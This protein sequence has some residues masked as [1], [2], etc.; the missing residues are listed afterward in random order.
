M[1][2]PHW[3]SMFDDPRKY[4]DS[5][6]VS[7]SCLST[8]QE[9]RC[10]EWVQDV[11]RISKESLM[12]RPL[13]DI[14]KQS[15]IISRHRNLSPV[16]SFDN[17]CY[18]DN[19]KEIHR[20]KTVEDTNKR[21]RSKRHNNDTSL[22]RDTK[23]DMRET[24][25]T[26]TLSVKNSSKKHKYRDEYVG[27]NNANHSEVS[28]VL[29]HKP[30]LGDS[31][32]RKESE[33]SGTEL[34]RDLS[35]KKRRR[36][37]CI[38]PMLIM[39][40]LIIGGLFTAIAVVFLRPLEEEAE[41]DESGYKMVVASV[42]L[43][44]LNQT[45]NKDMRNRN[46]K[47]YAEIEEP[48]CHEMDG[49][50][51]F[52]EYSGNYYGCKVKM[53][54]SGSIRVLEELIFRETHELRKPTS[55]QDLIKMSSPSFDWKGVRVINVGDFVVDYESIKVQVDLQK[56]PEL[57]TKPLL[58]VAN[59]FSGVS[60]STTPISLSTKRIL[61]RPKLWKWGK[62]TVATTTSR[63]SAAKPTTMTSAVVP[64]HRDNPTTKA[65]N[66]SG[67]K[68]TKQ[69]KFDETTY[70]TTTTT[71]PSSATSSESPTTSQYPVIAEMMTSS[72][73]RHDTTTATQFEEEGFSTTVHVPPTSGSPSISMS[74]VGSPVPGGSV[75]V[76][77]VH[78]NL[79]KWTHLT[80]THDRKGAGTTKV[81]NVSSDGSPDP[82]DEK[83]TDR[84]IVQLK[85]SETSAS[86][87]LNFTKIDCTDEG[88]YV[89]NVYSQE[90][91]LTE[92]GYLYIRAS[93]TT[94]EVT[95][96]LEIVDQREIKEPIRCTANVGYPVG[97]LKWFVKPRGHTKFI[98]LDVS[99][100]KYSGEC[101]NIATSVFKLIP[102]MEGNGTVLKCAVVNPY[103]PLAKKLSTTTIWKVI[104]ASL[105]VGK[106]DNHMTRHP[107]RCDHYIR[108]NN[109]TVH[110]LK[111]DN[112]LCFN[113]ETNTCGQTGIVMHDVVA[114]MN[115]GV[116]SLT[117]R[118]QHLG[119]WSALR[120][121]KILS[122]GDSITIVVASNKTNVT[123]QD[124]NMRGR[125]FADIQTTQYEANLKLWI[126]TLECD[127]AGT[128][129]C[130]ADVDYEL[131]A[132]RAQ[133]TLKVKPKPPQITSPIEILEGKRLRQSFTCEGE[134]GY[135]NGALRWEVKYKDQTKFSA[136][137]L[138]VFNDTK[139][140]SVVGNC[141]KIIRREL[142]FTPSTEQDEMVLRCVVENNDTLPDG[143]TLWDSFKVHV[144]PANFCSSDNSTY[145]IH[146]HN[147]RQYI[148]CALG[149][150]Y[151]R[152]CS[153]GLCFNPDTQQCDIPEPIEFTVFD[154]EFPCRPNKNG[155]YFPHAFLCNKYTWCVQGKG[156]LQHCP[157]GTLYLADGQCTFN[158]EQSL[159]YSKDEL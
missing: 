151:V 90:R 87:S 121:R 55:I 36:N 50:F 38:I 139:T 75:V 71:K 69:D 13:P 8:V 45:F 60:P 10:G 83:Y 106:P 125:L 70:S 150:L 107:Y 112:K 21:R 136:V 148:Q 93:P 86:V 122:S 25:V 39:T 9:S 89:C 117:C 19:H 143:Q 47:K 82:P 88:S 116:T 130:E 6:F 141:S 2:T 51:L 97:T 44:L 102:A 149:Y 28:T 154:P 54:R 72:K 152:Q 78:H 30:G 98:P 95:M 96:P 46:T 52:S 14:P 134:V 37:V 34:V 100:I 92:R 123:I 114:Y 59:V 27:M 101:D 56:F 104:P 108:C 113:T 42:Q 7:D 29:N 79:A 94:P 105:C 57:P 115:E 23:N 43:R 64:D 142:S 126:Y 132:T 1:G 158:T 91:N 74:N 77:C 120:L 135:P 67:V 85:L 124:P 61:E 24:S 62:S 53:L 41:T 16:T 3:V 109:S 80:V 76:Q 128:Y 140:K 110:V 48:L 12:S 49:M 137:S 65:Q 18:H 118:V 103:F 146:P 129:L 131:P 138:A 40:V 156:I 58:S 31:Y 119:S 15:P 81:L 32:F 5:P 147:C 4:P 35:R 33:N 66:P 99:N 111:C 17:K 63:K 20:M 145:L 159:C 155:V 26:L 68:T 133:L 84:L 127:D 22:R 144:I 73:D 157:L 153:V 11:R